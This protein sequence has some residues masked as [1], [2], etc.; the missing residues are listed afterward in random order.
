MGNSCVAVCSAA[1]GA[2]APTGGGEEQ[3]HIVAATR[4]QLVKLT[5]VTI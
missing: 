2:S 4:L 1:Q 5:A 3:G